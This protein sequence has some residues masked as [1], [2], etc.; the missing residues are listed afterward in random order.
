MNRWRL[1]DRPADPGELVPQLP[2]SLAADIGRALNAAAAVAREHVEEKLA[3]VQA[4]LNDLVAVGEA[5]EA[6]LEELGQE[7]TARTSERDSMAGQLAAY[8]GE[9]DRRFRERDRSRGSVLGCVDLIVE[10]GLNLQ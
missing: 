4:E 1:Q 2:P 8:F 6:R 9:R 5:N 7:L 3:Q 10:T